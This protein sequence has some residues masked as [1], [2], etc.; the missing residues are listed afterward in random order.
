MCGI[1]GIFR[2]TGSPGVEDALAVLRMMDAQTHRGPDDWGLLIPEPLAAVH[3]L[4]ALL[5]TRDPSREHVRVY[6]VS[7]TG[8]TAILGSRRLSIIDRSPRGRMPMGTGGGRLWVTHNGEIYNYQALRAEIAGEAFCSSADTEVIL[9]GYATWREEVLGRLRGMFAFALLETTPT[10]RL[11]LARDRFGI[12]PLYYYQDRERLVFASEVRALLRSG[13]VPDETNADALVRFLQWGTVPVPHTTIK[14]VLALPAGHWLT[15]EAGGS[16][17]GSYSDLSAHALRAPGDVRPIS[18]ADAVARTR[19]LLAESVGLHLAG[20]VPLGIFLSG[21]IDSSGLVALAGR[22]REAPV[23]TLS[24]AY[25][26]PAYDEAAYARLA[27]TRYRTEH[28]EVRLRAHDLF[29]AMARIFTAMDEPTVDG[30]NTYFI[31]EAARRAGLTVV[32]SGTGGD[33]VFFGY[34]HLRR[35]TLLDRIRRLLAALPAGLRR[36]L[37]GTIVRAGNS[38]GRT[39]LERLEYLGRPSVASL[40]LAVRGLFGPGQIR[41]LLGIGEAELEQRSSGLPVPDKS[42]GDG[43]GELGLL[44]FSHYLQ[45]Q[46]LKDADVMGMAHSVEIRVPYLDHRLVEWVVSLPR[47]LKVAGG[48][49]KPLL[50]EALADLPQEIWNRPKMGFTFPFAPWMREQAEDLEAISLAG[51]LLQPRAVEEI[52]RAFRTGRLHWS[53][54]WALVVL[55]CFDAARKPGVAA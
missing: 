49:H 51:R 4:R 12:K 37:I 14:D 9:R 40:Y 54:A 19:A 28:R 6:A 1:A 24:I 18:R 17:L 20:E 2:L 33:E 39:G 42:T 21:G 11:L 44:E 15:V 13:M 35:G 3:D 46:L 38:V 32:L 52:W 27:A 34:G 29:E 26:E 53:R 43:A 45:N 55:A 10:P 47:A 30:V 22:F 23:T 5:A 7:S 36:Q 31:S 50:I 8:P 16:R 48:T 25:D 41:D